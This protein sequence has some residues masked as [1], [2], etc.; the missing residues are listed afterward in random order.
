M[1]VHYIVGLLVTASFQA[2]FADID[3]QCLPWFVP[4]NSSGLSQCVCSIYLPFMINCVQKEFASYL[5]QGHCAFHISDSNDTMVAQCPYVFPESLFEGFQL[6][7]PKSVDTV[8][9]FICTKLNREVGESTCGRCANGTGPSV[10]SIGSQCANCSSV[11]VLYYILLQYLPA[12]IIFLLVLLVKINVT[13]APMAHY[14]LFCNALAVFFRTHAGYYT[15][16]AFTETSHKYILRAFLTLN[17][18]WSFDPLYFV[19]PALCLSPHIE[20]IDIPYIDI[21]VTLY[22][23]LLLM[24]TF[25]LIELHA[26]D[27]RLL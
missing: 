19:S 23:F 11:N 6:R 25:V 15:V 1:R 7:L 16:F 14:V 4:D 27:F 8:N 26:R 2:V 13:S 10:T 5:M 20:D 22:P 3:S 9:S 21:L 12:T 17:A 18:I 24:L